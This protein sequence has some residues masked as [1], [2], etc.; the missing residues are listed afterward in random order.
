MTPFLL[1]G[2][3]K[4][5]SLTNFYQVTILFVCFT[6]LNDSE[7][8]YNQI[9]LTNYKFSVTDIQKRRAHMYNIIQIRFQEGLM[10]R[11]IAQTPH[12][13]I[14]SEIRKTNFH[15][16]P[17][18]QLWNSPNT[19]KYIELWKHHLREILEEENYDEDYDFDEEEIHNLDT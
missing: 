9:K 10:P 17:A 8:F 12:M 19:K 1:N 4:I 11:I 13:T 7:R 6:I 15:F 5:T 16:C 3:I 14:C 18:P 2:S